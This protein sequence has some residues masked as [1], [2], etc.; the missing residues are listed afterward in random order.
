MIVKVKIK[1]KQKKLKPKI[2]LKKNL[3]FPIIFNKFKNK[4]NHPI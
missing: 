1:N 4:P 2:I 3:K